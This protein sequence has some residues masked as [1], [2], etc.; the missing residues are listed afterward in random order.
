MAT[1]ISHSC[2]ELQQAVCLSRVAMMESSEGHLNT[3]G[4]LDKPISLINKPHIQQNSLGN[5]QHQYLAELLVTVQVLFD[6]NFMV[7]G[8]SCCCG[9]GSQ[10]FSN[11]ITYQ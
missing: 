10:L 3:H 11:L 7:K 4:R 6:D 8:V 1:L 5:F 9:R 2:S